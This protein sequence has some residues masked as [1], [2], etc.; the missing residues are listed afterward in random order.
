MSEVKTTCDAKGTIVSLISDPVGS[1]NV[2]RSPD[3][4]AVYENFLMDGAYCYQ[5]CGYL[6]PGKA[7]GQIDF[8]T[9]VAH[10]DGS[11]PWGA[12]SGDGCEA[13][14]ESF[15]RDSGKLCAY[16]KLWKGRGEHRELMMK[17]ALA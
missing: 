10:Q 8:Y 1:P 5:V 6:P 7:P 4:C 9:R 3:A 14:A 12:C 11:E 17:V 2:D 16:F 15:D 13:Y